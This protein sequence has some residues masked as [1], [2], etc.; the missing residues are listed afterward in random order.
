MM[1]VMLSLSN[2]EKHVTDNP[3]SENGLDIT[4][5]KNMFHD[6]TIFARRDHIC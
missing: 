2:I 6:G 4:P 3:L 5:R 1:G